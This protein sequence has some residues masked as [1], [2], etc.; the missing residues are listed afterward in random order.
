MAPTAA[1]DAV[2]EDT[3]VRVRLITAWVL[4]VGGLVGFAASFVLL[5]ERIALLENPFYQPS[6]S[7][8]ATLSCGSVMQSAQAAAFGFPNPVIGVGAFP[9]VTTIGVALLAGARLPR[10][11]WLGL[12]VGTLFGV[13]FIHWLIAQSLYD[14]GAL[15]PYCMIVWA[16][17]IPIFWYTTVHNVVAGNLRFGDGAASALGRHHLA[18]LLFWMLIVVVLIGQRFW[19][20]WTSLVT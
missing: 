7:I 12:Q 14:I 17:M 19:S 8:D 9:V 1:D 20:Y 6:C 10:W 11:F 13:G 5:L 18:P 4:A 16:V 2:A 3:G 15:C